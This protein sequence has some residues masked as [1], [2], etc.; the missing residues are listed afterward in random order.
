M[1]LRT[2][3]TG[4]AE[5]QKIITGKSPSV[6]E[7]SG[8]VGK[9]WWR[10]NPGGWTGSLPGQDRRQERASAS[11]EWS[12]CPTHPGNRHRPHC[13]ARWADSTSALLVLRGVKSW[14]QSRNWVKLHKNKAVFLAHPL[15]WTGPPSQDCCCQDFCH[16]YPFILGALAPLLWGSNGDY[17]HTQSFLLQDTS[18][19]HSPR[20]RMSLLSIK[21]GR[22]HSFIPSF[23]SFILKM[24]CV[25]DHL[26]QGKYSRV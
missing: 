13:W 14:P 2:E 5:K 7:P 11:G 19:L 4:K 25:R 6:T 8:W 21:S 16:H 26:R 18:S 9:S 12:P 1:E 20:S 3:V 23:H 15:L 22:M 17:W 24:S 10:R